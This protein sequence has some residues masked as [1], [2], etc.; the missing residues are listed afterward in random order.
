[1][2][3]KKVLIIAYYWPPSGGIAVQRW[4]KFVK[5]LPEFGWSPVVIVPKNPVYPLIDNFLQDEIPKD[6][7]IIKVPI[8]EPA[9]VLT[10]FG[11]KKQSKKRDQKKA[12][13][14]G[15]PATVFAF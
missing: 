10:K 9:H 13:L 14:W 7:E 6:L 5:Y 4:L 11:K 1:M 15:V 12:P 8:W 3:K 2:T